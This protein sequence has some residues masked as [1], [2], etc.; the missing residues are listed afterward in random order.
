M[1]AGIEALEAKNAQAQEVE[2]L[3]SQVSELQEYKQQEEA[4]L[5]Q[6]VERLRK[7]FEGASFGGSTGGAE[8][9]DAQRAALEAEL[10]QMKDG[11]E[12]MQRA[13]EEERDRA[14]TAGAAAVASQAERDGASFDKQQ[15]VDLAERLKQALEAEVMRAKDTQAAMLQRLAG[16]MA[17]RD[18]ALLAKQQAQV[19]NAKLLEQARVAHENERSRGGGGVCVSSQ[20]FCLLRS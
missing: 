2:R 20:C 13:L 5:Q 8:A 4:R 6:E 17:E 16:V 10:A 11:M 12:E 3:Q 9:A 15:T 18:D 19:E 14:K 7:E 1:L